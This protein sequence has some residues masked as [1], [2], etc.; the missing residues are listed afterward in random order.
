[1]KVKLIR[2]LENSTQANIVMTYVIVKKSVIYYKNSKLAWVVL[3]ILL[4]NFLSFS[5]ESSKVVT[6]T[7]LIEFSNT[8]M[9]KGIPYIISLL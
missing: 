2:I 8:S 6:L 7:L 9:F 1:M 4:H 5:K 3:K